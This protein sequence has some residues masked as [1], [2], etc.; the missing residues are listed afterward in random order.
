VARRNQNREAQHAGDFHAVSHPTCAGRDFLVLDLGAQIDNEQWAEVLKNYELT[1]VSQEGSAKAEL[2]IAEKSTRIER[3]L[4]LPMRVWVTS[5]AEKGTSPKQR[6]L[7]KQVD[8]LKDAL[9]R[10]RVAAG[11]E[12]GKPNAEAASEAWDKAKVA[13]NQYVKI[14]NKGMTLQVRNLEPIPDDPST[15]V[16]A[17]ARPSNTYSQAGQATQRF[18]YCDAKGC[19]K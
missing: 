18:Q 10:I 14:A 15:Y 11:G 2:G 13:F 3:D 1:S 4:V 19:V 5:F 12:G 16:V 6:K 8:A 9:E 17:P 7:D